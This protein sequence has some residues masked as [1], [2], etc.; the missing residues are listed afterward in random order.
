MVIEIQKRTKEA[1][2]VTWIGFFVNLL[3]AILKMIA[4]IIGR[5]SALVAD[6]I[7]SLSDLV[8]DVVVLVGIKA[9]GKPED[10]AHRYGHGKIETL[11]T[12]FVGLFLIIVGLGILYA[13]AG[14]IIDVI[15]GEE[16]ETPGII[17]L[18]A[19][20]ISITAKEAVFW[21][22]RKVAKKIGSSALMANAWHHRTDSLSSVATLLGVGGAILLGGKWSVLDPLAA[23]LVTVLIFWVSIKLV[24]T[25]LNELLD[26]SLNTETRE[27]I[28]EIASNVR[29]V[30]EPHNL[31]TRS[32]GNRISIDMH[33]KVD[34]GLSVKRAHDIVLVLERSLKKEFGPDSLVNIHVDPLE[35]QDPIR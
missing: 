7:H 1:S 29:G 17:A 15:N 13:A 4:G 9:A 18:G 6:S 28:M 11:I 16:L 33:I 19:A 3:L 14:R 34:S 5:S 27:R 20:A 25:S 35:D 12:L 21:Y 32:L 24:R 23:A 2:K 22:T 8:T 10:E 26:S 31:K 30:K